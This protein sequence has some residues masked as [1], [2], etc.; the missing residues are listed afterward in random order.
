MKK[1]IL[2]IFIAIV[3]VQ[4]TNAQQYYT[5]NGYVKFFSATPLENIEAINNQASCIIDLNSGEVVSKILMKAFEFEKALMQEHFNENYI[6]SD[7]YPLAVFK[8]K[9]N[10]LN[11]NVLLKGDKQPVELAGDLTIHNITHQVTINGTLSKSADGYLATS[12][13]I[14]KPADYDIKVPNAVKDH[15]AKEVEVSLH[16]NLVELKK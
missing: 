5:R 9:I 10:N 3:I 4:T 13:F 7:K 15:I 2:T 12:T 14:V 16:F 8:A 1:I 11:E 6:E